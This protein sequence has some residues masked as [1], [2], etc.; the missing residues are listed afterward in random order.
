MLIKTKSRHSLPV[1]VRLKFLFRLFYIYIFAYVCM[2]KLLKLKWLST[3]ILGRTYDR[4]NIY[5]I[6]GINISI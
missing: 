4:R 3:Y 2:L 1:K 6:L 5:R